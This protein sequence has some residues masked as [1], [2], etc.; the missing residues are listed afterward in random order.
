MSETSPPPVSRARIVAT[1]L[2]LAIGSVGVYL[3]RKNFSVAMP[4]LQE[5]WGTSKAELGRIASIGTVLYALGKIGLAP[6]V[7]RWGGRAGFLA[8]LLGVALFCAASS[9]A[10]GM[11]MLTILYSLNRFAGAAG[12]PAMMKLVPTWVR[13]A[14]GTVVGWLSVSYTLGG[15]AA[16]LLASAVVLAGGGWRAVMLVPALALFAL[17]LACARFVQSGPLATAPGSADTRPDYRSQLRALLSQRR[18]LI[19]CVLSFS[20]TLLR[21]SFNT[22]SVDFLASLSS[23]AGSL[24][25]AALKSTAF[26]LAGA[27]AIVLTGLGYDRTPFAWRGRIIA[28]ALLSLTVVLYLLP[29]VDGAHPSAAV[30]LMCLAGLLVY[31]PYSLLAGVFAVECGGAAA[32]ATASGFIDFV[33]YLAAILAGE[34]LGSILDV[35]G[36]RLGFHSLAA[37]SYVSAFVA[38]LL[39]APAEP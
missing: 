18:F 39:K 20:L 19:V 2:A 38:L 13:D 22:W 21:E 8:S 36:Y 28:A 33:G 3:C 24:G 7:D 27:V 35:G 11:T 10:P 6:A 25:K 31:A 17:T 15:A 9:L 4:L 1:M 12:W 30:I 14:R 23:G 32:A 16:G 26:D 34:A 29:S 5:A 37:L